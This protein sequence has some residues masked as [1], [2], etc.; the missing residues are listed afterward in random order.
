MRFN[1]SPGPFRVTGQSFGGRY[2]TVGDASGKAIA[3]V[4]FSKDNDEASLLHDA[5]NANLLAASSSM[6]IALRDLQASPNDPR[7]H[8]AALDAIKLA[9]E[10][11]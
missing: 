11:A 6:L 5:S 10:G 1:P 3:R 9:T 4:L 8:R 7:A 2:I